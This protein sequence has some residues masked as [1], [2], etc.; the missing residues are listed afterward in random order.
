MKV[1][2]PGTGYL[3]IRYW[4]GKP[5]RSL[6]RTQVIDIAFSCPPSLDGKTLWLMIR[7][8]L[9]AGQRSQVGTDLETSSLLVSFHSAQRCYAGCWEEN[10]QR[11]YPAMDL[12]C[13]STDLPGKMCPWC[14]SGTALIGITNCFLTGS[15]ACSTARN[16][17]LVL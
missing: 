12:P 11:I 17:C 1:S 3:P 2:E 14:S 4:L 13:R 15:E 6:D 7:C 16:S 10:H 9:I 5:Q 8:G